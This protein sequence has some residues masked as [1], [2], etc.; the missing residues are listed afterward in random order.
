METQNSSKLMAL[1][2]PLDSQEVFRF[3][4]MRLSHEFNWSQV[5]C[6]GSVTPYLQFKE[7]L[8]TV[9]ISFKHHM[10]VKSWISAAS[11]TYPAGEPSLHVTFGEDR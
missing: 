6:S 5:H 8:T 11:S 9:Y 1:T 4:T 7:A 2:T 10:K 3:T